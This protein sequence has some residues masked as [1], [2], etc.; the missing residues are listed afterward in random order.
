MEV[1]GFKWNKVRL[2]I[3]KNLCTN[4][5]IGHGMLRNY[6]KLEMLFGESNP[7]IK[8]CILAEA[9]NLFAYLQTLLQS[10][11]KL[12]QLN[13][14]LSS[15]KIKLWRRNSKPAGFIKKSKF[16]WRAQVIVTLSE[17]HENGHRQFT[18]HQSLY[19]L[20]VFKL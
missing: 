5:I 4:I 18:G 20:L 6:S 10:V 16:P 19:P 11:K 17:H 13:L 2:L 8:I 9:L 14:D 15:M 1:K 12:S 7:P 3:I